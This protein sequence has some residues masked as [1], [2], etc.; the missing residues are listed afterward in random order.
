VGIALTVGGI[1]GILTQTPAGAR[2]DRLR[3]HRAL[4]ATGIA[5]LAVGAL[6]IARGAR[7]ETP[8]TANPLQRAHC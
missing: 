4:I 5:A 8:K 1:A 2:V 7:R 3:Y 6:L